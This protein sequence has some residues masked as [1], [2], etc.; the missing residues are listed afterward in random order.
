M[1]AYN[2]KEEAWEDVFL[3][4]ILSHIKTS[5]NINRFYGSDDYV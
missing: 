5:R 1:R 4:G 3:C 2:I